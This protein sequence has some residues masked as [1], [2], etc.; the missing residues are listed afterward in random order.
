MLGSNTGHARRSTHLESKKLLSP[1][2]HRD[3]EMIRISS[4]CSFL[5]EFCFKS[6]AAVL[7]LFLTTFLG[8][9]Y[10]I[11]LQKILLL[12]LLVIAILHLDAYFS[13][14]ILYS[15]IAL[16]YIFFPL[17]GFLADT[18][19]GRYK[20]I[21]ISLTLFVSSFLIICP[22][23]IILPT[24]VPHFLILPVF[25]LLLIVC[26]FAVIISVT[27]YGA[28]F[29]QFGLDQ[30]LDAPSQHQAVFVH[31]AKWCYDFLS[32]FVVADI[33]WYF[34][35][36]SSVG[37]KSIFITLY[38]FILLFLFSLLILLLF[39]CWKH[40]W[41]YSE[42]RCHNPYKVVIMVLNFARKHA[43]PLQRSAFTY[44][45]DERPSRLDFA[46][47][48]FGGP[49]TTEQVEDVK[50]FLRIIAILSA[51]G[52]VSVLDVPTSNVA[53]A[54]TGFHLIPK[55]PY[56]KWNWIL[57]NS[58]LLRYII[59]TLFLPTY[60]W[61]IFSLLRNRIPKIFYR[62]GF[63]IAVSA[64]AHVLFSRAHDMHALSLGKGRTFW[65]HVL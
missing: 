35:D 50:T 54:F 38:S 21:I 22:T 41:F 48:R 12:L 37:T 44:C 18:R 30:L 46:K 40:H 55:Y 25:V 52:L 6:K 24:Y 28:N 42:P 47:E 13:F 17:S 19:C 49:F 62:L 33:A 56:C 32:I 34:C 16:C 14:V 15:S 60:V 20:I 59:S 39:S 31:W 65:L 58:G 51:V 8:G 1:F 29:I 26:L 9:L 4:M 64:L 43:Y 53:I 23:C 3:G 5:N 27:G 63:G 36:S 45:D 57:V 61:I 10:F 7:I 11:L 2:S